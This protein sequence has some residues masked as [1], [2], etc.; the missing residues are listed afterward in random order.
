MRLK[1][2]EQLPYSGESAP[3]RFAYDRY[4]ADAE[5][6]KTAMQL[7]AVAEQMGDDIR[8]NWFA[9]SFTDVSTPVGHFDAIVCA[10]SYHYHKHGQKY[11][12]IRL[13]TLAAKRY[14]LK[15]Q[16]DVVPNSRGLLKLPKG[17]FHRDGRIVTFFG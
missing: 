1:N 6:G 8:H 5:R 4:L 13:Y 11:A 3:D 2:F 12:N 15:H 14:F 16:G 9:I 7:Q 17:T 10:V